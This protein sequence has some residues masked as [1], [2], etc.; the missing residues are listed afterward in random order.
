MKILIVDDMPEWFNFHR[1]LI[2]ELLSVDKEDIDIQ[3]S[4][5]SAFNKIISM[6]KNYYDLIITDMQMEY[7]SDDYFA[8]EWLL[9][10]IISHKNCKKTKFLIISSAYNIVQIANDFNVEYIKKAFLIKN[11]ML[12]KYQ[13]ENLLN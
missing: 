6:P 3:M 12:M 5:K 11:P 2:L 1:K 10:N 7:I 13:I 9:R 8:G 4:A